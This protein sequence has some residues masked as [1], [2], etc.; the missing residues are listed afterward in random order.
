MGLNSWHTELLNIPKYCNAASVCP[1]DKGQQTSF[2]GVHMSISLPSC[3]VVPTHPCKLWHRVA[4][5]SRKNGKQRYMN[6]VCTVYA[7]KCLYTASACCSLMCMLSLPQHQWEQP[8]DSA[9]IVAKKGLLGTVIRAQT[10]AKL[11]LLASLD[12][13]STYH[14]QKST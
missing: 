11:S 4:N 3:F 13:L 7:V 5:Q 6:H 14:S 2:A 10:L 8:Y 1:A 9:V 12:S